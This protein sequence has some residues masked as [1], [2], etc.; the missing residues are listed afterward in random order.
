MIPQSTSASPACERFQGLASNTARES[1]GRRKAEFLRGVQLLRAGQTAAATAALTDAIR[2]DDDHFEAHHALGSALAQGGR[3]AEAAEV[4]E[5]AVVL[6]P[7]SAAAH[8][9]LGGAYDRQHLHGAAIAAFRRAVALKPDFGP[10]HHRLAELYRLLSQP[11]AAAYHLEATVAAAPAGVQAHL[12]RSDARML[13][14]DLAGAEQWAREAIAAEPTTAAAHGTLG[15]LLYARGRFEEAA[16]HFGA[17]LRLDPKLAKCWDGLVHCRRY[18]DPDDPILERLRSVLERGDLTDGERMTL[19]FA[20]GKVCD[21]R[22]DAAGAMKHFDE[23][24]ALRA[25]QG[26]FD[27][28]SFVAKVDR[29][30]AAFPREVIAR[31]ASDG[32]LDGRPLFIVGMYRS[33][34][35]LVEQI[36]SRHPAISAGG[37]MTVWTPAEMEVDPATGSFDHVA[38]QA[39]AAKYLAKLDSLAP[40]AARVTDKLPFNFLRLGAI[41]SLMPNAGIIHCR[42]DPIDTCLSIPQ[43]CSTPR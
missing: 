13:R 18:D 42:R 8:A 26:A 33:G 16:D 14:G 34:T 28:A 2:A 41:C 6:R 4:L 31:N 24:N 9:M 12:Y 27:R 35:T 1:L 36:L 15:G 37:E 43:L 25:R 39:S 30:I 20:A 29:T 5:R 22:S 40:G 7:D 17:A 3:F 11:E 10:V 19:D 38:G 21:D 23:A 32:I